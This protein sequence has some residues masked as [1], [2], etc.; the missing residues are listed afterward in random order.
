MLDPRSNS[1]QSI[2]AHQ[3]NPGDLID[4]AAPSI[5]NVAPTAVTLPA[6]PNRVND[7]MAPVAKRNGG[8]VMLGWL[9]QR[10]TWLAVAAAVIALVCL[11]PPVGIWAR[12]YV[13]V[14]SLQFVL[15]AT[16][17]PALFVLSAP[18]HALGRSRLS[19]DRSA[20]PRGSRGVLGC[21]QMPQSR[22][23]AFIR[24]VVVLLV[25]MGS[26]VAWRVPVTVNA[27]ARLPGLAVLEMVT[28][29]V[30]GSALWLELVE[31]PPLLPRLLRPQRAA[32]AALAMWTIWIVAY[33]LGFSR[34]AWYHAYPHHPGGLS[35]IADQQIATGIMWAVP[36]FCFIPLVFV[37]AMTWLRYAED[38]D[39]G[40]HEIIRAESKEASTSRW[41]R[42]PR[43]WTA[44]GG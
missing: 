6:R 8:A 38:P 35:V 22:R 29:L 43:G 40:L 25:F 9:L 19:G 14:E 34:V 37:V 2:V 11:L 32:F 10:R 26:V 33:V 28:L 20:A 42:P 15:F 18:W 16:A 21:L 1:I 7:G 27:L 24:G 41:P 30:T 13:F 12:R 39:Q 44:P 3:R 5:V 23:A 36:A 4:A 17:V 31:S